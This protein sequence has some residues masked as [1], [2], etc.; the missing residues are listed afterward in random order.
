MFNYAAVSILLE[1]AVASNNGSIGVN[2]EL[3][4]KYDNEIFYPANVTIK[5]T[6]CQ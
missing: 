3:R 6:G 5:N 1:N 2:V 4:D